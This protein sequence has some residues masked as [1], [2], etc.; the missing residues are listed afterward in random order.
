MFTRGNTLPNAAVPI[1]ASSH[2]STAPSTKSHFPSL[3]GDPRAPPGGDSM[4]VKKPDRAYPAPRCRPDVGPRLLRARSPPKSGQGNKLAGGSQPPGE[5][6][7]DWVLA[8]RKSG[9]AARAGLRRQGDGEAEVA[10]EGMQHA[11]IPTVLEPSAH[12]ET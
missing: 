7:L 2:P 5:P 1:V 4:R 9:Q 10:V 3:A 8:R 6:T 12:G 11:T